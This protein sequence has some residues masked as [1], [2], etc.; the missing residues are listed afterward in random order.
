MPM[1][2][3]TVRP[4]VSGEKMGVLAGRRFDPVR[5]TPMHQRHIE[6]GARMM[7]AG[8]WLRPDFYGEPDARE[9]CIRSEALNVRNNVGMI[10]RLDPGRNR[11]SGSGRSRVSQSDL[12]LQ[13][14]SATC[15]EKPVYPD[16]RPEWGDHR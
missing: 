2:T 4:P 8:L 6:A 1:G 10:R 12:Y 16:V 14:P 3:T 11:N 5:L 7:T 9:G 13:L 15:R